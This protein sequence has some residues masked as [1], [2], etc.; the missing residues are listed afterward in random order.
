M[1]TVVWPHRN[2][3]LLSTMKRSDSD[4]TAMATRETKR[5]IRIVMAGGGTGGHLYPGLALADALQARLRSR[6]SHAAGIGID[7]GGHAAGCR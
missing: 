2:S 3:P 6:T 4:V 5:T 1:T 7:L